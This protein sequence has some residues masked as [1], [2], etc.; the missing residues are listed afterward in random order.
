M[1]LDRWVRL[2]GNGDLDLDGFLHGAVLLDDGIFGTTVLLVAGIAACSSSS[3]SIISGPG[4][5]VDGPE[6]I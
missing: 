3:N 5:A 2:L 6:A 1:V 4:P